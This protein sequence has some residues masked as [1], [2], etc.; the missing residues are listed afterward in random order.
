[1]VLTLRI[2]FSGI[3][4]TQTFQV[5]TSTLKISPNAPVYNLPTHLVTP[6]ETLPA[7]PPRNEKSSKSANAHIALPV[8]PRMRARTLS[9]GIDDAKL[10]DTKRQPLIGLAS[11]KISRGKVDL[12]AAKSRQCDMS[13][14]NSDVVM[15]S[16]ESESEEGFHN[17]RSGKPESFA[18]SRGYCIE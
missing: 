16:S 2:C 8:R 17:Q 10:I 9:D 1:M 18:T 11:S 6:S 13:S 7:H 3:I 12:Y 14:P 4:N 5:T 15:L